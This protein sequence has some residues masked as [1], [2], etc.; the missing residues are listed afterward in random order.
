MLP[1][2]HDTRAGATA[3][4][5]LYSDDLKKN[6]HPYR[7]FVGLVKKY[8]RMILQDE[9]S[10]NLFFFLCLNLSFAFVELAYGV[11]TNSLGLISDGFHM[12]FDCTA[13]LAGLLATLVSKWPANERFSYGY[14]RAEI[15]G[16]FVNAV[17]LVFVAFFVLT[18]ALE[19]LLE[20]P[21]VKTDRLF[22]VSVLGFLVNI[23]GIFVFQHGGSMGGHGHSHDHDHGHGHGHG[24]SGHGHSHGG[25]EGSNQIM[26]GVFLHVLAD[27]LGSVGVIISSLLIE[28]FG[29]MKADPICSLFIAVMIGL[30]VLPLLRDSTQVLLQR[31]PVDLDDRI[32]NALQQVHSLEGVV[33]VQEPH[34]W[35]L[36]TGKYFGSA[37]ILVT[38]TVDYIS[39]QKQVKSIFHHGGVEKMV[40]EIIYSH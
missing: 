37:S 18:E 3:G 35:T 34:F 27:T 2:K 24:H 20:P 22:L 26:K 16:G 21:E 17:L 31:S 9:D 30:S 36:C 29:W 10:R 23:V 1:L 38:P 19:R 8:S 40:V 15:L 25:G 28:Y 11:W 39:I 33:K 32:L 6:Q 12:L 5:F 4:G 13:L 14:G 7:Y